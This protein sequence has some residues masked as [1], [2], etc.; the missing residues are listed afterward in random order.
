ME[1]PDYQKK[2]SK[3]Q[4]NRNSNNNKHEEYKKESKI[5]F[6]TLEFLLILDENIDKFFFD[7]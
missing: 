2:P 7:N 5:S 3:V 1:I 6:D 4:K